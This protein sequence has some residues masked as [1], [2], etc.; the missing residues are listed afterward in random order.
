V[1]NAQIKGQFNRNIPEGYTITALLESDATGYGGGFGAASSGR[2]ASGRS[3][4]AP[5]SAPAATAPAATAPS[6]TAPA[7]APA[8]QAAAAA[9]TPAPAA[10]APATAAPAGTAPANGTYTFF[11]RLRAFSGAREVNVYIYRVVVRNGYVTIYLQD[12]PVETQ[13]FGWDLIGLKLLGR[14]GQ[15]NTVL[16]DL[17]N[18]SRVFYFVENSVSIQNGFCTFQNVTGTRFS[19]TTANDTT[20]NPPIVFDE[21]ILVKPD[22]TGN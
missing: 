16:K 11:P 15:T 22:S 21:I 6:T 7:T 17:D 3:A 5:A 1:E 2:A 8:G 20:G 10:S 18:P 9:V 14:W 13:R 12:V 4:A 19:L